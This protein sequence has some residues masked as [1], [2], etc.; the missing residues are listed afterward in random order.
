MDPS[1]DTAWSQHVS[2]SAR[3]VKHRKASRFK[4]EFEKAL[5]TAH[6]GAIVSEA[7]VNNTHC[8]LEQ[9]EWRG[10]Y[11]SLVKDTPS[12]TQQSLLTIHI[13]AAM[14][15]VPGIWH[16]VG[17]A[18]NTPSFLTGAPLRDLEFSCRRSHRELL[19]WM[20]DYKSHCVRTSFSQPPATEISLRRELFGAALECLTIVKRLLAT[21][22]EAER[23]QLETESVALARLILDLQKQPSPK[24]SWLFSG[25]EVGVAYTVLLT[26]TQ[27][28]ENVS[29]RTP[30]EQRMASR[31]RYNQ[32]SNTLRMT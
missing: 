31:T 18:V 25:H 19:D 27:W 15:R 3:L 30:E 21:V 24:H 5:F 32:W 4:T 2:G 23:I 22:C 20:E 29:K 26:K 16:E 11:L 12:L 13:R 1:R 8:Y 28:E 17:E 6:I 7:L 10:L 14:F 9:P